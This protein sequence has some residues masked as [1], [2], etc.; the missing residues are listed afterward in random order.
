MTTWMN[1]DPGDSL[2]VRI[3]FSVGIACIVILVVLSV[4]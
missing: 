2:A 3:I 4:L 1:L